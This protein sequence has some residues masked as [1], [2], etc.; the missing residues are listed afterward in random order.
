MKNKID[1]L[2]L[3]IL[4]I[5]GL[6][7]ISIA[8]I[9]KYRWETSE[10]E[11]RTIKYQCQFKELEISAWKKQHDE[12]SIS[13]SECIEDKEDVIELLRKQIKNK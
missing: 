1:Y 7:W 2:F 5:F 4:I 3:V 6:S 13:Y 11:L 9:Y 12:D 8:H 10:Q